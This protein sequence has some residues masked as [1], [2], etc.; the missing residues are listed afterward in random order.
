MQIVAQ[1]GWIFATSGQTVSASTGGPVGTYT[2]PTTSFE[3]DVGFTSVVADPNGTDV[4]F[5]DAPMVSGIGGSV[6]LVDYDRATF[7]LRNSY[8]L[9]SV[10]TTTSD[11]TEEFVA[12]SLVQFSPTGFAFRTPT[13]V[14]I[15]TLP[16]TH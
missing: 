10:D 2:P 14:Y 6:T 3:G 1:G 15:V 16:A 9:P 4:W 5:L 7:L 13:T 8:P 12:T 11:P